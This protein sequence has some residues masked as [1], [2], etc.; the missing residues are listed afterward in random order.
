MSNSIY[1]TPDRIFSYNAVLNFV[2]GQRGCGKTY[3]TKKWAVKRFLKTG[4]KFIYLRRYKDELKELDKFFETLQHDED[5]KVH[6]FKVQGRRFFVDGQECGKADC[7]STA[8]F[9][10]GVEEPVTNLIIFD[11]FIIAKSY[12][13][14]LPN[15]VNQLLDY[16][17]SVFRNRDNCRCICLANSISWVNPYFI[18]YKFAP[19][20]EGY[21]VAQDGTVV[22]NVYRNNEFADFRSQT[23]FARLVSGT[24]YEQMAMHNQFA[25]VTDDF[26]KAKPKN[27]TLMCN[28]VWK[29]ER[30]GIWSCHDEGCLVVSHR[31][32]PDAATF[33][34]TTKDYKPNMKLITDSRKS[35]NRELK[36]AFLNG[37]LFY[38]DVFI[39]N[40]MY[41]LL[42]IMGIR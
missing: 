4:E 32:N 19:M 5:L 38:E 7:L 1:F 29:Q 25:D 16:I 28:I 42:T 40:E 26:I 14:Y 15:E 24:S 37:Y 22:L 21:Q 35:V 20:E 13:K 39:R 3:G 41:D 36:R 10:K 2:V 23:R 17:D 18:F 11:E 9:K 34:Y 30:Y 8:Q 31:H 6:Q 27:A 12:V 33:C